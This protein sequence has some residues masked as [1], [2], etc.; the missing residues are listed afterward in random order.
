MPHITYIVEERE[1]D[2]YA[3]IGQGNDRADSPL[4]RSENA[5]KLRAHELAHGHGVKFRAL[6]GRFTK[7]DCNCSQC[8]AG[9]DECG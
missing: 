6:N 7:P 5:A 4:H 1:N 8:R 9:C 3:V 2:L